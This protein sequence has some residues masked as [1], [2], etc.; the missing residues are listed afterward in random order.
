MDTPSLKKEIHSLLCLSKSHYSP[1]N[2]M[3]PSP[4]VKSFLG[5]LTWYKRMMSAWL[6]LWRPVLWS[7]SVLICIAVSTVLLLKHGTYIEEPSMLSVFDVWP[8]RQ[9]SYWS[10]AVGVNFWRQ[11]VEFDSL[12]SYVWGILYYFPRLFTFA[13]CY[14][15]LTNLWHNLFCYLPIASYFTLSRLQSTSELISENWLR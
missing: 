14:F 15:T 9:L 13:E 4:S 3:A 8:A 6:A 11:R 7:Y 2:I 1:Q 12:W 10:R 5:S